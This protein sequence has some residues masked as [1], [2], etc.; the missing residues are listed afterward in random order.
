MHYPD[1]PGVEEQVA[2]DEPMQGPRMSVLFPSSGRLCTPQAWSRP[3]RG[4]VE[5]S[6]HH[7]P[8][9]PRFSTRAPR[10]RPT[11]TNGRIM[12][13]LLPTLPYHIELVMCSGPLN[14]DLHWPVGMPKSRMMPPLHAGCR[15]S[16]RDMRGASLNYS[17]TLMTGQY[18]GMGWQVRQFTVDFRTPQEKKDDVVSEHSRRSCQGF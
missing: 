3:P 5:L 8:P 16:Y 18:R 4:R 9:I 7:L 12:C 14:R 10:C 17:W 6:V 15:V 11:P 1:S 2:R 13:C